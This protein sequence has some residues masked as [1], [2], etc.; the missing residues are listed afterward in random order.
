KQGVEAILILCTGAFPAFRF[1][2][3]L[4]YP[5]PI[6]HKTVE[7]ILPQG[8]LGILSPAPQQIPHSRKKWQRE[9]IELV[10][11]AA[12]P[13]GKGEELVR[14]AQRLKEQDPDLIVMDCIGYNAAMK[15]EVKAI[16]Q[17][18]VVLSNALVARVIRE[19][20]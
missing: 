1:S 7:G 20:L 17:K 3:L 4:L 14:A 8:R 19:L 9:G 15:E 2:G 5:Q 16:T 13:Y 10:M 12:S 18:P 6:L 11:E